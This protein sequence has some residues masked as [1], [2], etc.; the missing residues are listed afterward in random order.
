M[1]ISK[2]SRRD[3][4]ELFRC[5]VNNGLLDETRVREAV[6]AVLAGKP[7]G[8]LAVLTQ[9]QRLVKLDMDRRS[10]KVESAAALTPQEQSVVQANLTRAYGPG[11]ALT[12]AQDPALIGGLRVQVGSDVYDG[13]VRARLAA[14]RESF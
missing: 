14:L 8:Y 9:F 12:F 4:R 5:C 10:A 3:A 13:S 1:K 2:Q 7:R 6:R 11:L